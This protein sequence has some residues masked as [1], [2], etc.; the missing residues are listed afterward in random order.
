MNKTLR[1]IARSSLLS[2]AALASF[3]FDTTWAQEGA[4]KLKATEWY[5]WRGPQQNGQSV[6]TGL[7]T[8]FSVEGENLL[9]RKEEYATRSTPVVMNGRI[10][11]VCRDEPDT[12]K[13]A[14]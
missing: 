8:S 12:N 9:W 2:A 13:E 1:L 7:P 14:E 3:G 11:V 5:H 6:E 10:Y 4:P